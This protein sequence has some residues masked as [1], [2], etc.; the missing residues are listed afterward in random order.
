MQR[1]LSWKRIPL[2]LAALGITGC[3]ASRLLSAGASQ[4]ID[5]T[6]LIGPMCPV[7]TQSDPCPDQ[8]Y[9]AAIVIRDAHG[10]EV[11]TVRSGP[12]GRFNVGLEPGDYRLVPEVGDPLPQAAPFD[13]AVVQGTWAVVTVHYDT[14]IR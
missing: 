4:G 3:E 10:K 14:G 7:M 13:V 5:G 12:D 8:P 11:T 6:V 9:A 1:Y 2:M